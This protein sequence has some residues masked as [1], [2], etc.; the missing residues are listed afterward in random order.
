M[1]QQGLKCKLEVSGGQAPFASNEETGFMQIKAQ[2][3][4]QA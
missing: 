3:E 1:L 2:I 4:S